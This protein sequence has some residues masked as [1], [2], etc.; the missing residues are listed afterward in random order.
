MFGRRPT[1][2]DESSPAAAGKGKPIPE[3]V[4]GNPAEEFEQLWSPEATA[5]R[6]SIEQLLLERGQVI[7]EQLT[8]ARTVQQ[9]TPGKSIAQILLTMNAASE[10]Q[11]LSAQAETLGLACEVPEK[12][13]VDPQAFQ[14]LQADYIR[15]QL[16]L[17]LR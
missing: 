8:Q 17:P 9:Q 12:A 4:G 2:S 7:E 16:V 10:P 14:M 13:N 15:K 6:K 5:E 3:H 11:I 1:T